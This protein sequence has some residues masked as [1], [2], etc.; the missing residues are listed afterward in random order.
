ML[1]KHDGK[2]YQDGTR[3]TAAEYAAILE[4]IR[5][6]AAWVENICAGTAAIEDVPAARREEIQQRVTERRLQEEDDPELA[7]AE[8]LSII[9]GGA[10]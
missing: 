8:A 2:Y 10:L 9:V 1:I 6:E 4:E 3:I 5:I 7:D